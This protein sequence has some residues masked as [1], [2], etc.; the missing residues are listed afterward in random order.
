MT[1]EPGSAPAAVAR[2]LDSDILAGIA[3][4]R[5]GSLHFPAYFSGLTFDAVG[6]GT[7]TVSLRARPQVL[8]EDANFAAMA[9]CMVCDLGLGAAI[10]ASVGRRPA[11]PTVSLSVDY[12]TDPVATET[13]VCHATF[14]ERIGD[15]V[16]ARCRLTTGDGTPVGRGY[17]RFLLQTRTSGG[18]SRFPWQREPADPVA[19][20]DLT[21][22]E[23]QVRDFLLTGLDGRQPPGRYER[24]YRVIAA[25]RG[26]TAGAATLVQPV[27]PHLAN[28]TGNVQGGVLAGLLSDACRAAARTEADPLT[29][30]VSVSCTFIRPGRLDQDALIADARTVF[31]GRRLACV[32]AQATDDAGTPLA[33]AEALLTPGAAPTSP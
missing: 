31:R 8:D 23:R 27:G 30:L 15:L 16:A 20:A 21:A 26:T 13:L 22:T 29:R 24:L 7:C 4:A 11:L 10:R 12:T 9:I 14:V 19:V 32:G 33:R 5:H 25:D 3:A 6:E 28:R 18:F 17:G 1:K 2:R